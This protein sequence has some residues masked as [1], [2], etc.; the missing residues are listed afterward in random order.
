M[1]MPVDRA[2]IIG[3]LRDLV[4]INS[5]NPSLVRDAPGE[6]EVASY[7]TGVAGDLGLEVQTL[8]SQP[9]RISVLGIRKGT[10]S[11]KSLMLNAHYDTVG[12]EGMDDPFSARI[13]DGTMLGRGAY[14]MKGSLAACVG[15]IKAL[16]DQGVELAGDLVLAAVAD[17][18]HSSLGTSDVIN[19]C[20]VDG[21]IVTE[22]SQLQVC[23]AHKG[24]LWLEIETKGRAAHG[25]QYKEGIDAI[26][27]M[28]RVL[29]EIERL[30]KQ[31]VN[32]PGHSLLGPPSMHAALLKGGTAESIYPDRCRLT[33]ERRTIP[34][35]SEAQVMGEFM[36]LI[37]KLKAEDESFDASLK[38]TLLRDPFEVPRDAEIV[39]AVSS[40][41]EQ[42]QG[43]PAKFVGENPWM[44]SALLEAAGVETVVLGPSGGGAHSDHEWVELDSVITLAEILA[45]SAIAYCGT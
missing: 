40:A 45:R 33:V 19:A 2:F 26:V 31:F 25:S 32:S 17:E 24:F 42:V 41:F 12:V 34:G 22:P 6:V 27:H 39:K 28:G 38:M 18:E 20:Q 36:Q 4:G 10:G 7:M 13:Q 37:E 35:E 11:G 14:D 8:A 21:A 1:T 9:D 30:Q 5:V 44:D 23:L 43:R 3:V 29:A 15:A 16:D